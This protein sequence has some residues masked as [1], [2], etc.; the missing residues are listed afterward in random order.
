MRLAFM[1]SLNFHSSSMR[2]ELSR[3]LSDGG[4]KVKAF[5]II[6]PKP[7]DRARAGAQT[8]GTHAGI[9][10]PL[11][12]SGVPGSGEWGAGRGSEWQKLSVFVVAR[13]LEEI[14]GSTRR[15]YRKGHPKT[16]WRKR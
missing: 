13:D 8:R 3:D 9:F 1:M 6:C 2:S 11:P 5:E 14:R 12:H 10:S 4:T 15:L 7:Q 16:R